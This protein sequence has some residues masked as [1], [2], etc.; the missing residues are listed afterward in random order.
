MQQRVR[1]LIWKWRGVSIATPIAAIATITLRMSGVLEPWELGAFDIYLRLRPPLPPDERIAIVGIDETDLQQQEAVILSDRVYADLLTKLAAMKPKAIGLDMYRDVPVEPGHE[2]LNRVFAEN[3]RII[4]IQKVLGDSDRETIPP[5]LV[6]KEK[7]KVGAND[8]IQDAD[9]RVRRGFAYVADRDDNIITSFSAFLAQ[10]Y[11]EPEGITLER[12][13]TGQ[14]RWGKTI[15]NPVQ[16]YTGGYIRARTGRGFQVLIDYRGDRDYFETV[17]L[18]DILEEK[19]P[20]DWGRDRIILIGALGESANDLFL[21]PFSSGILGTARPSAGV[22]IHAQLVSQF[23]RGALEGAPL[24]KTWPEWMEIL[25][26]TAWCFLGAGLSWMGRYGIENQGSDALSSRLREVAIALGTAAVLFGGAYFALLWG[27]WIPVIPPFLGFSGATLLVTAYVARNAGKIRQTFGRYLNDAVVENLLESA[28]GLKL[29]GKRQKITILTSDLR[30]FTAISERLPPE[31]VVDILNCFLQ[32]MLGII[33]D[34]GG[35]TNELMGDGVL[36]FFGVPTVGENDA[37]NAVACAIAMQ[38]AMDAV[39][40]QMEQNH[41]PALEM[42]IGINTGE[43]VVGNLGSDLH[44]EYKAVGSHVN[45]TFRIESYTT[46]SQ[47]MISDYT[48]EEIG[49]EFVEIAAEQII[50][51]K[52]VMRNLS[53]YHI[54][55]V[56]EPFNLTIPQREEI[57]CQLVEPRSLRYLIVAGKQVGD[58]FYQ[59]EIRKLSP[60]AAIIKITKDEEGSLP[61][62]MTNLKLNFRTSDTGESEGTGDDVYAKAIAVDLEKREF[63]VRFTYRSPSMAEMLKALYESTPSLF[64]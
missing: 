20:R 40:E 34:Y 56:K 14:W 42:G 17:P 47:I 62:P 5:P 43:C 41:W 44:T 12:L 19:V 63:T 27:W 6:L 57:F 3:D 37:K 25:W 45:L 9:G 50:R 51:P 39:N 55:R 46:G 30:G 28:E 31:T 2:E 59:G 32:T 52:G 48:L 13:A 49:K 22:E 38:L 61:E 24:F 54:V 23:I 58:R 16:S 8:T 36:A 15:L 4:G 7:G 1:S 11:L 64:Q 35:M 26:L 29:G 18:R 33:S 53:I 10:L 60:K 21:T